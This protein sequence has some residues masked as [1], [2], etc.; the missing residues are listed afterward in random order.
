MNRKSKTFLLSIS[1]W[2]I[3]FLIT[4][5]SAVYQRLTGPTYPMDGTIEI[6]GSEVNYE[7]LRSHGGDGDQP[8]VVTATDTSISGVLVYRRY[9]TDDSWIRMEMKR[10]GNDLVSQLPHQPPAG[11]LEYYVQFRKGGYTV[12]L[13]GDESVVTRFKGAVPNS[14]LI[15][16]VFLMFIGMLFSARVGL[17][18]FRKEA[19]LKNNVIVTTILIFIG[20]MIMGPVVQKYAFDAY[21]T[22]FPFGTDLTDNKTLIA[23]I[24]WLIA[25][26][27]VLKNY[28]PRLLTLAAALVTFVVFMI[29]HSMLGSELDYSEMDEQAYRSNASVYVWMPESKP[30]D[31]GAIPLVF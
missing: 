22:G 19:K 30:S 27:G 29:P 21:W 6:S 13:P 25:L 28:K 31:G 15:V 11:K 1:L 18:T 9:P 14:V 12:N 7:L 20:G 4:A 17:E 3:A 2:L 24:V 16:H 5:A 8:V 23:L 26:W 10:E